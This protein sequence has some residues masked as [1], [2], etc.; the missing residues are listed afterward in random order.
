MAI[1]FDLN[2][3]QAFRAVAE[4]GNFRRAAEAVHIS[5]PAF[6]RRIEKLEDALGVRLMD[7]TTRRVTLTTVGR[8]FAKKVQTLLDDLDSTLLGLRGV[9]ATRM[10]VVT[11]A[12]VPST[13]Y[14]TVSRVVQVFRQAYPRIRVK[15]MDAGANEVLAAVVRGEADFGLNFIGSQ[16]P[17]VDFQPLAEDRF[18]LAC[19][20]DHPLAR[21]RRVAWA[22]LAAHDLV[23]VSQTSGNRL[24]IDQALA[25]QNLQLPSVCEA[26]HVTGQ[27]GL[28]EAGL[29]VAAVPAMAMPGRTHPVLASVPLDTPVVTRQ[30]GLIRR[31]AR[32]L[33]PAA[34]ALFDAFAAEAKTTRR[35]T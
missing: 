33:A 14:Y 18:V 34:Q 22:E 8:D 13:V 32:T 19:R 11:V 35:R 2:D 25:A 12:C 6:S 3:L 15:V 7:R 30:V 28:V 4:L 9:A 21:R 23:A 24:L 5:Q 29:G 20:R 31:S 17:G 16:E 27:L 10:G 1:N 26:Q